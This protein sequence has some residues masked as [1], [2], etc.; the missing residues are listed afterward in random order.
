MKPFTLI[1]SALIFWQSLLAQIIFVEQSSEPITKFRFRQLS[2]GVV[3]LK[4]TL[5]DNPDSLNFILDT[6]SGGIS[7][8]SAT[9]KKLDLPLTPTDRTVKGLGGVRKV[10]YAMNNTLH[11]PGIMIDYLNF[12]V[13][14]YYLLTTVYGIKIDGIIG[15]S[16]LN[17]YIVKIN[18]DSSIIEFHTN[19]SIRYPRGGYL[20]KPAIS[21]IPITPARI[22]DAC[23][24]NGRFY[25]DT[26]AGL[27]LL[28]SQQFARDSFLIHRK[29]NTVITQGEG[30]GGKLDL[31]FTYIRELRF[32]V[33]GGLI[34]NDLLRRFNLI[35]NYEKREIH[36]TPNSHFHDPFDYSYT[37][38]GIYYYNGIIEIS[39]VIKDSPG[40]KAGLEPGDIIVSINNVIGADILQYKHILQSVTSRMKII[41]RRND[42]LLELTIKPR[43]ITKRR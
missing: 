18:Y 21:T 42:Q 19:G 37:G 6:G 22:K 4:G 40:E 9:A 23:L 35:L 16:V 32:P 43:N 14:D 31:E 12:H 29:R 33:L 39:D 10:E 2:G 15:Y 41:V 26:G 1:I 27:S 25:F 24:V 5:N 36:L 38:L 34:G 30:L 7:L 20:L 28:L 13:T 8:D 3:L 17:Q 11:L